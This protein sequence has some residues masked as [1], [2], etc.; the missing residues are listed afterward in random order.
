MKFDNYYNIFCSFLSNEFGIAPPVIQIVELSYTNIVE[1]SEYWSGA[2]DT[3]NVLPS[4]SLPDPGISIDGKPDF[5]YLTT[6]KHAPDLMLHFGARTGR[7]ATD[8][9]KSVLVFDFRAIGALGAVGKP[10]ADAWY[11]RAHETI[12]HCFTSVTSPDIQA[13]YWQPV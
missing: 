5:N 8:P 12:R 1:L 10:E 3:P 11:D 13:R 4:I 7:V 6:Y 9:S 2:A